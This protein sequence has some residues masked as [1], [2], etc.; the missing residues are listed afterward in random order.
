M[1]GGFLGG[2]RE[3]RWGMEVLMEGIGDNGWESW[4]VGEYA[5]M[6]VQ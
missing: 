5:N 1:E 2:E 4:L 3:E 6:M